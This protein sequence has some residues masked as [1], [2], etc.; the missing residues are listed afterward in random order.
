VLQALAQRGEIGADALRDHWQQLAST[1]RR[2]YA[3]GRTAPENEGANA[4]RAAGA[5]LPQ[6]RTPSRSPRRGRATPQAATRLDR[7]A[8]LLAR[9]ADHWAALSNAMHAWLCE[10]PAPH[11]PFFA[12]LERLLHDQGPLTLQAIVSELTATDDQATLSALLS[13]IL[14]ADALDR[15]PPATDLEA[16]LRQIEVDEL[17]AELDALTRV[18]ELSPDMRERTRALYARLKGLKADTTPNSG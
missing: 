5:E 16:V 15:E 9:H 14:A 4:A 13:R 2:T 7:A 8:W 18:G 12:G 6:R 17:K 11:G 10:Q 3:A 1:Q